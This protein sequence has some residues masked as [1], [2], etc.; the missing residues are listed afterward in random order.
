[1]NTPSDDGLA[2][3]GITGD[4]LADD[5]DDTDEV[6]RIRHRREVTGAASE[7]WSGSTMIARRE[8]RRRSARTGDS[9]D[10]GF[11][12]ASDPLER[13]PVVPIREAV[14]PAQTSASRPDAAAYGARAP[15]AVI[16]PRRPASPRDRTATTDV[17]PAPGQAARRL[18]ARR[19]LTIVGGGAA[20]VIV[21]VVLLALLLSQA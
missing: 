12:P 19:L 13:L 20:M 11:A 21:G 9:A 10:D 3:D 18:A 14:G 15:E 4:V 5:L 1:M 7:S 2:D 6:T 16:V 17:P 8:S